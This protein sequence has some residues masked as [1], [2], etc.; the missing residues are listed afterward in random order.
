MK[1]C[2]IGSK[3]KSPSTMKIFEAC[4]KCEKFRSAFFAPTEGIRLG[5]KRGKFL[6][7]YRN[8]DLTTFDAVIPRI[9]ASKRMFGYLIVKF[10]REAGVYVPLTPESILIAHD[11]FLTLVA[12]NKA[13]VPIPETYL[14]M[15]APT[16]KRVISELK[17]PIVMKLLGGA[18]GKGVM[19]SDDV[20]NA[21]TLI[22]TLDLL[23]QPLFIERYVEN[24]GEDIRAIVVG[25]Q[26]VASMKRI[27]KKGER[28]AN[29]AAGGKGVPYRVDAE[30]EKICVKAAKAIGAEICAVDVLESPKGPVVIE[31]NIAPGM[32][33][34]KV[35]GVNVPQIIAEY[36]A[37]K[38]EDH[39]P[40]EG[41]KK[42]SYYLERVP[43]WILEA[44]EE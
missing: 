31:L 37:E 12:L 27:A 19:F 35:T 34:S 42:I 10:L 33:I 18:G 38:A 15:S 14:T 20:R 43:K 9:G 41:M 11:K 36:V 24:P 28:R 23:K 17:P 1:V 16:A 2:V 5:L 3:R 13:K 8:L 39:K 22:D 4:K 40:K 30:L 6:I 44:L 25:E 29:L 21:I 32:K 7:Y 26:V